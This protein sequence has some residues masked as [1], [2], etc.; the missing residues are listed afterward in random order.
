[1]IFSYEITSFESFCFNSSQTSFQRDLGVGSGTVGRGV[2]GCD[3]A[4]AGDG[5]FVAEDNEVGVRFLKTFAFSL[6]NGPMFVR[7]LETLSSG[8]K[9]EFE[10]E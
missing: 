4:G 9:S 7:S 1:M 3:E 10:V 5:Y 2:E 8:S 6:D